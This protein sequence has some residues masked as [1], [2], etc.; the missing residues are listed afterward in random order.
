MV[1]A[2]ASDLTVNNIAQLTA[3]GVVQGSTYA[4]VAVGFGMI[5]HI[6]HRFHIAYAAIYA[7]TAFLAAQLQTAYG[8]GF[9]PALA[10]ATLVGVVIAVVVERIVYAPLANRLGTREGSLFPVF[11]A[12]LGISTAIE[13]LINIV[14][15]QP[16]TNTIDV[17]AVSWGPIHLTSL[18]IE[19]IVVT[20]VAIAVVGAL[21]K[22]TRYG[23]MIRAVR[24]NAPLSVDFG[25]RP[26]AVFSL[27]F[28]VGTVLGGIGAVFLAAQSA[29]QSD[30][31]EN[32]VLY[33]ITAAFIAGASRSPLVIAALALLMGLIQSW[34]TLF[35]SSSWSSFVIFALLLLYVMGK[36]ARRVHWNAVLRRRPTA[37]APGAGPGPGGGR[38]TAGTAPAVQSSE[39]GLATKR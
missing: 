38:P 33:G 28:A 27:V 10:I 17:T 30:M 32:L 31:G 8:V 20:W 2:A 3:D 6:T 12:S 13:A 7:L 18:R 36:S 37:S 15:T 26:A 35:V 24:V 34:S 14:W 5:I 16:I 4:L 29:P 21:L 22:W 25:I 1:L 9:V 11:I 19:S 39:L 23:R